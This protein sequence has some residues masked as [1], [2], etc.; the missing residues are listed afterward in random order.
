MVKYPSFY[1]LL[2]NNF[3][4]DLHQQELNPKACSKNERSL[5][6]ALVVN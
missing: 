6:K 2:H 4:Q 1:G 3:M 5:I